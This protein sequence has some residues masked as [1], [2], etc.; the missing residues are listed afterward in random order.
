MSEDTV[1]V[2]GISRTIDPHELVQW[3]Q[4]V[5]IKTTD[6]KPDRLLPSEHDRVEPQQRRQKKEGE[7]YIS[8][9]SKVAERFYENL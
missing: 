2:N 6:R 8:R 5:D 3:T 4:T 9:F 7:L 1:Y